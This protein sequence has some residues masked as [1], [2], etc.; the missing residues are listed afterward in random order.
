MD[1][2]QNNKF[3]SSE[4]QKQISSNNSNRNIPYFFL[5]DYLSDA[6]LKFE[7]SEIPFHKIIISS[8][9]DFFF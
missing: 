2:I 6:I 4:S 3:F 5:K 8:A 1:T 7:Q 9:S